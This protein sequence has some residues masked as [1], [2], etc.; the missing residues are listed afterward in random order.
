MIQV[1]SYKDASLF[2]HTS[3]VKV[4]TKEVIQI[5]SDNY[6]EFLFVLNILNIPPFG[7]CV[8]SG[9]EVLYKYTMTQ[10]VFYSSLMLSLYSSI[11]NL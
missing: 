7:T 5:M 4:A 2:S 10:F 9:K 1:H 8:L 3:N 11:S 6:S